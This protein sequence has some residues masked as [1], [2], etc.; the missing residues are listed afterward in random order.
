MAEISPTLSISSADEALFEILGVDKLFLDADDDIDIGTGDHDCHHDNDYVSVTSTTLTMTHILPQHCHRPLTP[1]TP[2]LL[3]TMPLLLSPAQCSYIIYNLGCRTTNNG[4]ETYGPTYITA[5][6]HSPQQERNEGGED[7]GG[8]GVTVQLL[9]P[10][11]HKVCVFNSKLV[12][13]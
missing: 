11:H 4:G 7:D 10:N 12:L 6:S 2:L 5:A 9:N 1:H 8:D 13:T 3:E